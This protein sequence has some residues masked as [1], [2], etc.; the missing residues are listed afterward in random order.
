MRCATFAENFLMSE[1]FIR[2]PQDVTGWPLP[3]R[4]TFPFQY[5]PHPLALCAAAD[6]KGRLEAL[7]DFDHDFGLETAADGSV[8][9]KMFGVL[10][11]RK[12]SGEIGYLAAFSGK[13]AK[14]NHLPGFVPPVFDLLDEQGFFRKEEAVL[15]ALNRDLA[16]IEANPEYLSLSA[17]LAADTAT[18]QADI[19]AEKQ[20]AA[21]AKAVRDQR[22]AEAQ[23]EAQALERLEAELIAESKRDHFRLKDLK[24][25]WKKRLEALQ[26]AL[27]PF[28]NEL[29]TLAALRKTKSAALQQ[30][31]FDQYTFLNK[32]G[33]PKSLGT[34]FQNHGAGV[35]PAGAGECAAPKLLQFAFAHHL[36]PLAMAEFWWGASPVGEVRKH[37]HFYPACRGKC[38]P[39]L[40]HMLAGMVLD[41]NPNH[42]EDAPADALRIVY[43]DEYLLVVEKPA[44]MLSVPGKSRYAS[45]YAHIRAHCPTA[46]GPMIVH[47]LDQ[48]TSGLMLLAKTPEMHKDL[49]SQ[50]IRRSVRKRYVAV[51]RGELLGDRGTVDLPL[52]VD[53][54]NRPH[55]MVCFQYG[56][57]ARTEW[58]VVDRENGATRVYFYPITGRTHQLR[59]HAAHPNGLNAPILGDELYGEKADRLYLH[60]DRLE[61]THP[62]RGV[63]MCWEAGAAF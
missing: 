8:C 6:L 39:I 62:V 21:A 13:L 43:E 41:D 60:A 20:R 47:R 61:F 5:E 22:R 23:V 14:S 19:E 37:G 40:G 63:V 30:Q 50:F 9:G 10:V 57:S 42:A 18:A 11:V 46:T 38:E 17:Q 31:I 24:K 27:L 7:R 4:F 48:A 12:T 58:E 45:V 44:N 59:V 29:Q 16:R 15:T 49:Q 36:E 35:P 28:E 51:L 25:T 26:A 33:E 52:R 56:K 32:A 54:D 3:A 34:I 1:C 53:L 55:Q 2:F